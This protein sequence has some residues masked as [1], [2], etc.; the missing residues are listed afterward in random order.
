MKTPI[1]NLLC[2]STL[3]AGRGQETKWEIPTNIKTIRILGMAGVVVLLAVGALAQNVAASDLPQNFSPAVLNQFKAIQAEKAARS[4]AERKIRSS[5][6]YLSREAAGGLALA[7]APDLKSHVDRELDGRVIVDIAAV[8]NPALLQAIKQAGG[9]VLYQ[10]ARWKSIRASLLPTALVGIAS[11]ADVKYISKG[12]KPQP[13]GSVTSQGD[14]THLAGITRTNYGVDGTGIKVGVISDSCDNYTTA[15][16]TGDLPA[17]F[18]YLPGLSGIPGSGE[19]TAMSEIVHDLAPGAQ[20]VFASADGGEAAFADSIL[21]LRSNGCQIIVDDEVYTGENPFQ[22]DVVAQAVDEVVSNGALYLSAAGNY[23]NYAYGTSSTWEGDYVNGGTS[24]VIPGGTVHQ[25]RYGS[26]SYNYDVVENTSHGATTAPIEL[27]WS[28]EATTSSNDYD[29]YILN[30]TGTSVVAAST[31]IQNGSQPPFEEVSS[32]ATADQIVIFKTT[33][34][35]PRYL[36]LKASAENT[37]LVIG[38][39]GGTT[40]HNATASCI[41]VAATPAA[42]PFNAS[43]PAGPYPYA[44]NNN[45]VTESFSCDG[46]RKQFYRPDG[47]EITPGNLLAS[48][49]ANI[50]NPDITAADGVSTSLSSFSPF[51][52][53]SAAAPH[54]AAIA[55]L[56]WSAQPSFN[57]ADVRAILEYSCLYI[58]EAVFGQGFNIVSGNGVVMANYAV[59]NSLSYYVPPPTLSATLNGSQVKLSWPSANIGWRLV[60]QTNNLAKGISTNPND[61]STVVGSTSLNQISQPVNRSSRSE[62]YQLV[63]P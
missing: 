20:I 4:P 3:I 32:V 44:F 43:Y 8:P 2:R 63:F 25:F 56:V 58:D 37:I 45:D 22:D 6:L 49:G 39:A 34:A 21:M 36:R 61:W 26:T 24:S 50:A 31:D 16:G 15:I 11:R 53:T 59:A 47:S 52:G 46:P 19:G 54:A 10:S 13:Q 28:D 48:G 55:A 23:G 51:Y 9:T 7:G 5:L 12:E 60:E 1:K 62:F 14:W 41:G 17:S 29:L 30:S 40:G 38:T 18:T 27:F 35:A 33:S 42:T 57:N